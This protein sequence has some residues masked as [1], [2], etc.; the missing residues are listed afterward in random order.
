MGWGSHPWN[1]GANALETIHNH[2]IDLTNDES[3]DGKFVCTKRLWCGD[4]A[5]T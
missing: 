3:I 2:Q 5:V 1:C 4:C